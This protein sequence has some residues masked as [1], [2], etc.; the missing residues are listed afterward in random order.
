MTK[1]L[2]F[3]L[4]VSLSFATIASAGLLDDI[5]NGYIDDVYTL[6]AAQE[7]PNINWQEQDHT[8]AWISILGY[9]ELA[10]II[11]SLTDYTL[12]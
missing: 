10:Y 5:Q 1:L 9:Q 2:F 7:H 11:L 3:I 4:L 12:F 6:P 8:R